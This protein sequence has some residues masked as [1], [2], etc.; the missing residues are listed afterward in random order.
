MEHEIKYAHTVYIPTFY[1]AQAF[2]DG[3]NGS[4]LLS[5]H[6]LQLQ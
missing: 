2:S 4:Q 5:T 3:E 1:A 6:W